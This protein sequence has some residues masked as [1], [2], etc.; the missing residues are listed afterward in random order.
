MR[1]TEPIKPTSHHSLEPAVRIGKLGLTDAIV[2]QVKEQLKKRKIIKVKFLKTAIE[3]NKKEL[4]LDLAERA[5]A[6]IV[7][8]VGFVAVLERHK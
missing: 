2:R 7:H 3:D 5:G 6:K 8:R 1:R 4:I